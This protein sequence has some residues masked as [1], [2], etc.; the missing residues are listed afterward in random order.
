MN[1]VLKQRTQTHIYTQK[2]TH[3][4][5]HNHTHRC[6]HT[7]M[8]GQLIWW[9]ELACF[10]HRWD[11]LQQ[12]A[13]VRHSWELVP[14]GKCSRWL[15]AGA[16]AGWLAQRCVRTNTIDTSWMDIDGR[17]DEGRERL[18]QKQLSVQ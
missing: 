15:G 1:T 12:L 7:H 9:A 2:H 13:Q 6:K 18:S 10:W 14:Q 17:A 3:N 5:T 16:V 4:H 11:V 8:Q